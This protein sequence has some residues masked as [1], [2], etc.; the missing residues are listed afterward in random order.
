MQVNAF[1][2]EKTDPRFQHALFK[3]ELVSVSISTIEYNTI[4]LTTMVF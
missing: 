3:L 2:R 4:W 1:V